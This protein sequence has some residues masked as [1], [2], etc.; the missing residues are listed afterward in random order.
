MT[1]LLALIRDLILASEFRTLP[2]LQPLLNLIVL[3]S[4]W[5][6]NVSEVD[7]LITVCHTLGSTLLAC[8]S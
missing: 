5:I 2:G 3:K 7:V 8:M 6:G 1:D 4:F